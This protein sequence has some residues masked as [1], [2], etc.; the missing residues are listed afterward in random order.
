MRDVVFRGVSYTAS[1]PE[2]TRRWVREALEG[3]DAV[4]L[5]G[6]PP[7]AKPYTVANNDIGAF[8]VCLRT[9]DIHAD[10]VR[11]T[12]R[13]IATSTPPQ[14][15]PVGPI[16]LY[17]RDP[18]GIQ[19]QLLEMPGEPMEPARPSLHH[20]GLTV[21]DLE[22]A[23]AWFRD[24]LGGGE[25]MRA[26]AIGEA[27]G[28][29]LEVPGAAYDVALLTVGG[30]LLELMRFSAPPGAMLPP[31]PD[32]LGAVRLTFAGPPC[33]SAP[34]DGLDVHMISAEPDR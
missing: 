12:E 16:L 7:G 19:Y 31:A 34:P 1:D 15:S 33:R 27:P 13:G 3:D 2:R 20:I 24:E 18:D 10:Y 30:M 23:V 4:T 29:M 28:Q 9:A 26:S 14:Q 5:L 25:P 32:G 22:A 11:L 21:S 8:H 6:A 17:L